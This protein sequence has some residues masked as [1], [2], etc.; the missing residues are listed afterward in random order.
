MNYQNVYYGPQMPRKKK[1][2]TVLIIS[3]SIVII[4]IILLVVY[5]MF[6]TKEEDT[7]LKENKIIEQP[8]EPEP[9]KERNYNLIGMN[10][11]N[12]LVSYNYIGTNLVSD[13]I[14]KYITNGVLYAKDLDNEIV[15]Q[16]VMNKYYNGH[17]KEISVNDF[18]ERVKKIFDESFIYSAKD[19]S[20]TC[21]NGFYK[22]DEANNK[23]Y[24]TS[25]NTCSSTRIQ[26]APYQIAKATSENDFLYLEI[27]VL[28]TDS[29]GEYYYTNIEKTQL[30]IDANKNNYEDYFNQGSTYIFTFTKNYNDDYVFLKSEK[31]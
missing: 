14:T 17:P 13:Q 8:V 10:L 27:K 1:K 23:Y 2:N 25:N 5:I 19:Y 20:N 30:L 3:V 18:N 9:K 6:N 11:M 21:V 16:V 22:L 7:E 31:V 24:S 4:L 28:F 12:T 15:Y 29:R 26:Q